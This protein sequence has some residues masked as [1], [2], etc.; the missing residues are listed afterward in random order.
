MKK[1][2]LKIDESVKV[3]NGILCPDQKDLSIGGWQGRI[4][5]ITEDDDG[6]AI[7]RIEWDSITL[8]NMPDYYIDQSDEEDLDYSA[9]Y[10]SPDVVE[11]TQARDKKEDVAETIETISK[12]HVWG[13]LG[14]EGKRIQKVLFYV[15]EDDEMEALEAW[16]NYLEKTL[17]FPF[18]AIITGDPDKGPLQTG[19]KVNVKRISLVEEFHGIIVELRRG[20]NKYDHPLRYMEVI[21]PGSSNYQPVNDYCIWS[22]NH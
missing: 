15:N 16:E 17:S 1:N 19:D 22:G 8:K 14:E 10:L 9:M 6:N 13:W 4:S 12:T 11:L 7:V 3:K 20:H 18:D 5:E 2:D 21:N